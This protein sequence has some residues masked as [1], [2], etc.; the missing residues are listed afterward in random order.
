MKPRKPWSLMNKSELRRA[1][2]QFDSPSY[3][4]SAQPWSKEDRRVQREARAFAR[5]LKKGGRPPIGLGAQRLNISMERGLLARLDAYAR[6]HR[7]SR[8]AVLARSVQ[9]LLDTAA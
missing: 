4:P 6:R 1:T 9:A 7:L 2:S 8:A 3:H 5:A